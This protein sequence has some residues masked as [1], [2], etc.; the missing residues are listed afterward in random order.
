MNGCRSESPLTT[1]YY[2]AVARGRIEAA[3]EVTQKHITSA[4]TDSCLACNQ[5]GPCDTRVEAEDTLDRYRRL[6]KRTPG[7]SLYRMIDRPP[8]SGSFLW[9]GNV[10]DER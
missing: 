4:R 8:P 2:G 5:P 9:F 10:E 6:P 1:V 3:Q 7:A